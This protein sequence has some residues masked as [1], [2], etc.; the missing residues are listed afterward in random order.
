MEAVSDLL[1]SALV[2]L[3]SSFFMPKRRL[4]LT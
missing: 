1:I 3:F 4:Q 2:G